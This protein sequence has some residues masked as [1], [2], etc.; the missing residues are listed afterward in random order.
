MPG[1]SDIA[2]R[3][4]RW[5]GLVRLAAGLRC[6]DSAMRARQP[7]SMTGRAGARRQKRLP[8]TPEDAA[9]ADVA[10]DEPG[11]S[12]LWEQVKAELDL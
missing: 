5:R 9:E 4:Q 8:R 3:G 11:E 1:G 2:E 10:M 7:A 6:P 12:L